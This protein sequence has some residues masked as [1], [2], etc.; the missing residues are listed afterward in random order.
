MNVIHS[1]NA[2]LWILLVVVPLLMLFV[3][4]L[5]V[6]SLN[7]NNAIYQVSIKMNKSPNQTEYTQQCNQN[8]FYYSQNS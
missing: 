7:K 3:C 5:R 8:G 1:D 2:F 4:I 6:C